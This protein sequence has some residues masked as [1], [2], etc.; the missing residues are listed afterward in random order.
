MPKS[1][2]FLL[3]R[4]DEKSGDPM[5]ATLTA[6]GEARAQAY[7]AYFRN[8]TRG[9]SPVATPTH[10]IAAADSLHSTRSRLTLAAA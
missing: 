8:L 7:V 6:A 9:P 10:L 3:I 1:A 2:T 5:D 4:H